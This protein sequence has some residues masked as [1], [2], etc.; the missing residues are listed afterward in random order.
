MIV[1]PLIVDHMIVDLQ[2]VEHLIV[3]RKIGCLR[4]FRLM[5]NQH[6]NLLTDCKIGT[7]KK[8]C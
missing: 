4:K 8:L 2:S 3:N 1:N 7:A 6:K 5:G